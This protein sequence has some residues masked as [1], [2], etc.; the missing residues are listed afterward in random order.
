MA[1]KLTVF[2]RLGLVLNPDNVKQTQI[3]QTQRFNIGNS[4][5]LR[6]TKYDWICTGEIDKPAYFI[7][8]NTFEKEVNQYFPDIKKIGEKNGFVF[9]ERLPK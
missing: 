5:L 7:S 9:W 6:K 3:Q 4:E 1:K 2:Q 8:K